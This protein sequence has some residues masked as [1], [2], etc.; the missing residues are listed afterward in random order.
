[1]LALFSESRDEARGVPP[2]A[3]HGL[4]LGIELIDERCGCHMRALAA[5]FIEADGEILAHPIDGETEIELAG[6]HGLVAV[7]H[8]PGAC[9]SLRDDLDDRLHVEPHLLAEM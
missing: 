4:D 8:L 1:M 2:P 3:A 9:R 6:E 7:L 5:G